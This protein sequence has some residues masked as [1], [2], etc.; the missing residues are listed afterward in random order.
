MSIGLAGDARAVLGQ[1]N[2]ELERSDFAPLHESKWV[3]HLRDADL[4]RRERVAP[5]ENSD[6][7][8]IHPLRLCKDYAK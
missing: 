7:S 2:N 5:L 1:I 4:T 6:A 3:E 8:P